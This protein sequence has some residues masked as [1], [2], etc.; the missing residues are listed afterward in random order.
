MAPAYRSFTQDRLTVEYTDRDS[1]FVEATH[2][3]LAESVRFLTDFFE[4]KEAFP[5]I[6]TIL[7][8]DRLEFDR[9]VK[10]ILR[11]GIDVLSNPWVVAAP[12]R[13]DLVVLSP[14]AWDP[15]TWCYSPETYGRLLLHE[16]THI[17]EEYLSPNVE[18][19]PMWWSEGLGAYLS[20][21][22]TEDKDRLR[23]MEGIQ[24]KTISTLAD[25]EAARKLSDAATKLCFVWGW[26]LVMFI[27]QRHGKRMIGRIVRECADGDVFRVLGTS[28]ER[29]EKEWKEWLPSLYNAFPPFPRPIRG[30]S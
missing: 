18:A 7:V 13:T 23:V 19:A 8:P 26:T 21:Q 6:R 3:D 30:R 11:I 17:F 25:M 12:Q 22:W 14:L 5:P 2:Q 1:G 27:D 20:N 16:A 29:L 28:R 4:L 15:G 24:N 9:C 10:E